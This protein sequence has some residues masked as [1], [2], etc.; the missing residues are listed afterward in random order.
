MKHRIYIPV[1]LQRVN[2]QAFEKFFPTKKIVLQCRNQ[3]ALSETAR[4]TKKVDFTFGHKAIYH[5]GL[6]DIH[7]T[8]FYQL[9]KTLDSYRVFHK[10]TLFDS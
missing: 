8:V 1:F 2:L 4:T 7:I 6:V 9:V 5:I 10:Q 3:K